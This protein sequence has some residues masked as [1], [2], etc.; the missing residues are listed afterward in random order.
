MIGRWKA[1]LSAAASRWVQVFPI[2]PG[3]EAK[4]GKVDAKARLF[5]TVRSLKSVEKDGKPYSD[6][7]DDIM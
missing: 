7:M 1:P 4:P 6:A 2:E 3:Q 5:V